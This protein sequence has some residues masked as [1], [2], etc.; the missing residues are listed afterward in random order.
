MARSAR[1][2]SESL[3]QTERERADSMGDPASSAA[4]ASLP[5]PMQ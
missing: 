2:A 4:R 5:R 1:L 3:E